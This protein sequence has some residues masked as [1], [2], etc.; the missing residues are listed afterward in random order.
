MMN[1]F[2][3]SEKFDKLSL[4]DKLAA[5]YNEV[6]H[7]DE[8]AGQVGE[9]NDIVEQQRQGFRIMIKELEAA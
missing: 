8:I 7:L 9:F 1:P 4:E 6:I 2:Y 3:T 5:L